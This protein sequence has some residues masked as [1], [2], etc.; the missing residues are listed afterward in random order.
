[1]VKWSIEVLK[2]GQYDEMEINKMIFS[3]DDSS[4]ILNFRIGSVRD[5]VQG[6]RVS[7]M[8]NKITVLCSIPQATY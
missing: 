2:S 6:I 7:Y 1:M 3:N 5:A 4:N 8:A